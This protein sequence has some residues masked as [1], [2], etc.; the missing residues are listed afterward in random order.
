MNTNNDGITKYE[1]L[2]AA[3]KF[4]EAME[5]ADRRAAYLNEG[6]DQW[7]DR[8]STAHC[9]LIDEQQKGK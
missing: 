8:A 5:F 6:H 3:G 2:M 4:K 9:K 1:A 7:L